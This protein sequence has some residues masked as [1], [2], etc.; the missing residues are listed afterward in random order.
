MQGGDETLFLEKYFGKDYA[1][2]LKHPQTYHNFTSLLKK[3]NKTADELLR[4]REGLLKKIKSQSFSPKLQAKINKA[5]KEL[6][7]ED[8][9]KI[10]DI[11]L[12]ANSAKEKELIK[13][14]YIKALTY[15]EQVR[16][17]EAKEEFE[18][19]APNIM[20]V[21]ILHDYGKM[22][23]MLGEYDNAIEYNKKSLNIKL[24]T[25]AANDPSIATSYNNIGL[26]LN[27]KGE[28][29][30]AMEYYKKSLNIK[31]ITLA[32]NNPLIATS[33]NNIGSVLNDKG[34]YDKAMEYYKKALKINLSTLGT[35]NLSIAIN[36]NNIGLVLSSKG[37]YEKAMEYY[38]KALKINL[39]LLGS[40]HP[41]IATSYNN[42]GGVWWNQREY[43]KAIEYYDKALKI[44]I[45]IFG[46]KY[47]K[48]AGIYNNIGCALHSKG[49]NSKAIEYYEK[50]LHI[51]RNLFP[52]GHPHIDKTISSLKNVEE[53]LKNE[54]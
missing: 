2:I 31:L 5:F 11:F 9:R 25:L 45:A 20:N 1:I 14:H 32:E 8:T 51:L 34:E 44:F 36:Y 39:F 35:N 18:K 53:S 33:Y 10:L 54:N 4:E 42:I 40:N 46:E 29:D 24:T 19:I 12:A 38:N 16:Y 7:Y 22:Y 37:D 50:A 17:L 26:A 6:R 13:A 52:Y 28:H 27:N 21:D 47:P 3:T 48:I 43:D 15:M 49:E 23:C 41:S 30:K